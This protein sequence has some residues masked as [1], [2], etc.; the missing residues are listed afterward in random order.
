MVGNP[1]K[2]VGYL[3][4]CREIQPLPLVAPDVVVLVPSFLLTFPLSALS[5]PFLICPSHTVSIV[6]SLSLLRDDGTTLLHGLQQRP[7]GDPQDGHLKV[8]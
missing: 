1:P 5:S 2:V 8:F 4:M 7:F 3:T 6:S